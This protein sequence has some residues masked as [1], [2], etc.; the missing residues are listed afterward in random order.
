MKPGGAIDSAGTLPTGA[1]FANPADLKRLLAGREADLARNLTGR[2]MAYALGR[3]LE[4]YDEVVLDQLMAR[5]A[6]DGYRV[7]TIFTEVITSDLFTHRSVCS[8]KRDRS[9]VSL[10]ER[11]GPVHLLSCLD[12]FQVGGPW[13]IWVVGTTSWTGAA[14]V[15]LTLVGSKTLFSASNVMT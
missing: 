3:Q 15:S 9:S 6:E 2:F 5:I 10:K 13:G 14:T 8:E 4:G 12:P 1:T 7:R 11:L